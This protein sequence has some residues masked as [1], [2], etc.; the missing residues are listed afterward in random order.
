M[1]SKPAQRRLSKEYA[2]MQREPPPFIWAAPD[3][4]NI[5]T[6]NY[7]IRG[8]P[9]SPY[10]GGE[11][12]GVLLF[13]SEYPFK[14]P[15]IKMYTPSGRFQPDK[16]ICFSMSDFHP[17]SW[18]PAWSVQTILTGL[19]SF[20][21]SDEMTTGSVTSSD[22]HKRAFAARSHDWNLTQS[23]FRDAFPEYCTPQLRELPNMG[24]KERGK[25]DDSPSAST[26]P[27]GT[28]SA[29]SLPADSL[30]TAST[31]PPGVIAGANGF[32]NSTPFGASVPAHGHGSHRGRPDEVGTG[33]NRAGAAMGWIGTLRQVVWEKWRWCAVIALAVMVSRFSTAS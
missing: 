8:P 27:S 6:W 32:T 23:R 21:L 12:H 11:Y 29:S 20:M 7:L 28:Q 1:A 4:K 18:N 14:P 17:G 9:D 3:E 22:A 30:S 31:S 16:K 10:T 19:L 26:V 33:T 25:P 5:L 24:E 13:P 15:G 2:A